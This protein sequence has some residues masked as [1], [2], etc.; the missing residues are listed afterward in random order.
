MRWVFLP[1]RGMIGG[2]NFAWDVGA[3][4][5]RG[6]VRSL[7]AMRKLRARGVSSVMRVAHDSTFCGRSL[8]GISPLRRRGGGFPIAPATPSGAH[9]ATRLYPLRWQVAAALS[10]AVTITPK[11]ENAPTSQGR[12][13]PKEES[14]LFPAALR[15]R[16]VWGERR[17]S[18]RSGLSPQKLQSL[19]RISLR[20]GVRGRTLLY[21]EAF[22]PAKLFT[23]SA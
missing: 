7:A 14:S 23:F 15:E 12:V 2:A 16:G 22:S 4:R 19:Q 5:R 17:F 13:S 9:L 20:K 3:G 18:Q 6:L 21:R 10:A 1:G 11:Q 8:G